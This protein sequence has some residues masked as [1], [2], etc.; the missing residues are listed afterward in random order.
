[1]NTGTDAQHA[2]FAR[3]PNEL[4]ADMR[5]AAGFGLTFVEADE[6]LHVNPVAVEALT[7][8]PLETRPVS[9]TLLVPP[10]LLS[11]GPPGRI[12]NH[13]SRSSS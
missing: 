12:S 8:Q 4:L 6:Q 7:R 2:Y 13:Q 1:M 11:P 5:S 3:V 10:I 9:A